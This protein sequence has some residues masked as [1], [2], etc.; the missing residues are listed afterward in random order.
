MLDTQQREARRARLPP[1]AQ[2]YSDLIFCIRMCCHGRNKEWRRP[3][4]A[5]DDTAK[6]NKAADSDDTAEI[7][8]NNGN[9]GYKTL[10]FA[11]ALLLVVLFLF[12][13]MI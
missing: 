7:E 2:A 9:Q 5:E 4:R 12:R 3:G 1:V 10:G 13:S 11:A 8:V 6:L